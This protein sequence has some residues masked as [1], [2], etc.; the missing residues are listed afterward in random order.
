[1]SAELQSMGA[2]APID[3]KY[4]QVAAPRSLGE[5]LVIGARDRI[6]ADFIRLCRPAETDTVL[7]VGVSDV[8]NDAANVLERAYPH[9]DR[10]TAAG[11]GA[12]A[13]FRAAFPRVTYRQIAA[14][15]ALPF[16]DKTFDIAT[17]NAVLEH[18]G[19]RNNQSYF[20]KEL[21]R[22]ARKVFITVPHRYFPVEHHTA[23]PLLHYFDATFA[24]ACA[25]LKKTEW[26]DE[27]NLIL[28]TQRG[29]AALGRPW[30]QAVV[31]HTGLPLGP[32]SSNLFLYINSK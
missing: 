17:S 29:L 2:T 21:T 28:M 27:A 8:I 23:I 20:V 10:I 22:V 7:D 4:Y 12:A 1:M 19:S 32:F 15:A 3:G 24:A 13:E 30:P 11:L 16:A 9:P 14:N 5:R 31:G 18:V 6:Y 25:V 26:T